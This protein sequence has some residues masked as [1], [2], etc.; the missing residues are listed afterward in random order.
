[1]LDRW[2]Q[3]LPPD[4]RLSRAQSSVA[5]SL[6]LANAWFCPDPP[7]VWPPA[8]EGRAIWARYLLASE[9]A[10]TSG[11]TVGAMLACTAFSWAIEESRD[12]PYIITALSPL[13]TS[14]ISFMGML[15]ASELAQDA[16]VHV[17]LVREACLSP[18][19]RVLSRASRSFLSAKLYPNIFG[20]AAA[21]VSFALS[22]LA[23]SSLT[24]GFAFSSGRL[25]PYFRDRN[26]TS[27]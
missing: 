1:V 18:T 23:S 24:A 15:I 12:R 21:G 2:A 26:F 3:R 20:S 25:S 10:A 27:S 16:L 22:M 17:I 14:S 11:I 19:M 7:R 9:L 13:G 8:Q 4:K 6:L 5:V